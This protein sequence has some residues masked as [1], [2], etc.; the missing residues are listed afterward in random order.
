MAVTFDGVFEVYNFEQNIEKAV[1][2]FLS[3]SIPEEIIFTTLQLNTIST[4]RVSISC[5]VGEALDPP[6][7]VNQQSSELI[8]RKYT[9]SL[10]IQIATD[11]SIDPVSSGGSS[12]ENNDLSHALT[13]SK[14]RSAMRLNQ[15]NWTT[16]S[17]EYTVLQNAGTSSVNGIYKQTGQANSR[18]IFKETKN[19]IGA[20][21]AFGDIQNSGSNKWQIYYDAGLSQTLFYESP[22]QSPTYPWQV[23]DWVDIHPD[24]AVPVP[25]VNQGNVLPFYDVNYCRPTGTNFDTDED[26][27][28]SVLNYDINFV[29]R[30]DVL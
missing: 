25:Q 29:I 20:K 7:L 28:V 5:E 30:N 22:A 1:K 26:L 23:T 15:Q 14:I 10:S 2:T 27:S 21:I 17:N 11:S 16:S 24:G 12:F 4:P 19:L 3:T 6:D 18:P 9:A 8:Y 13:R